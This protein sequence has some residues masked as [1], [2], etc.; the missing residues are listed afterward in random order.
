MVDG[1]L[2]RDALAL[3]GREIAACLRL[4][5]E[6][7]ALRTKKRKKKDLLAM[8]LPDC[9]CIYHIVDLDRYICRNTPLLLPTESEAR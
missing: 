3:L 8:L 4:E 6:F 2:L 9:T 7:V 1:N 5:L